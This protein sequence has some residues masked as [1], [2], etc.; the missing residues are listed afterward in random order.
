MTHNLLKGSGRAVPAQRAS[1]QAPSTAQLVLQASPGP[2][3]IVLGRARAGP[4]HTGHGS[5]H[6]PQVKF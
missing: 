4:N 5:T 2:L 3:P 1:S 6:L